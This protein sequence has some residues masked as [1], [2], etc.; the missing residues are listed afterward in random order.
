MHPNE[1]G[2]E[3]LPLDESLEV[4]QATIEMLGHECFL[5]A[6]KGRLV[7][8][9]GFGRLRRIQFNDYEPLLMLEVINATADPDGGARRHLLRVPPETESAHEAVARSFSRRVG[10]YGPAVQK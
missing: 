6:A 10:D 7:Q 1:V 2:L 3:D 4:V 9:D 5:A 8:E